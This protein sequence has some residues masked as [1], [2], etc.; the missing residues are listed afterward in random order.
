MNKF[1]PQQTN[2]R[3]LIR[4][5][6]QLGRTENHTWQTRQQWHPAAW[7]LNQISIGRRFAQLH[8]LACHAPEPVQR[9]WRT[10]YANFMSK[11]FGLTSN[12]SGRYLNRWSCH[13]WM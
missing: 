2:L 10:T 11:H 12:T 4:Q 3:Y 1:R 7:K 8:Y 9:R 13:S 5:R 6:L